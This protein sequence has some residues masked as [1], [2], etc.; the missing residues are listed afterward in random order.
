MLACRTQIQ[1][2]RLPIYD[3]TLIR[4]SDFEYPRALAATANDLADAM[5]LPSF[6]PEP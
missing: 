4:S 1:A 5:E 6:V 2:F 3:E